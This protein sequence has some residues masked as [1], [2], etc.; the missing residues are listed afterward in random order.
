MSSVGREVGAVGISILP[1]GNHSRFW[2]HCDSHSTQEGSHLL[3]P[4]L[5]DPEA[6][7]RALAAW[8]GRWFQ[9]KAPGSSFFLTKIPFV[10]TFSHA[11]NLALTQSSPSKNPWLI[12]A[13]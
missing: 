13:V 12:L 8:L 11:G 1:A 10:P 3:Q 9:S 5:C 4:L 7:I 6:W 2:S